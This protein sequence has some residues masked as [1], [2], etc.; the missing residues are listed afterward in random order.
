[1]TRKKVF[2]Y[3]VIRDIYRMVY[4]KKGNCIIGITGSVNTGKSHTAIRIGWMFSKRFNI[5][6]SLVYSVENLI[7]RSL[8]FIRYKNR[9]LDFN[10]VKNIPDIRDWLKENMKDIRVSP[11]NV[12]IMDE[13]GALGAYV[14]EFYSMDNKN[15]AKVIQ[16]WRI[17]RIVCIFVVPEDIRLAESTISRFMNMEIKMIGIRDDG[18]GAN[19]VANLITGWNKRKK[20]PYKRRMRG[21]RNGG[22]II[23]PPLPAEIAEKYETFSRSEKI[24]AL[25][26]MGKE[27]VAKKEEMKPKRSIKEHVKYVKEH[28]EDFKNKKGV[29]TGGTIQA[30]LGVSSSTAHVIKQYV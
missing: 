18:L 12:I 14:R 17:L 3:P 7:D 11:G 10:F 8:H 30:V 13:T 9:S 19:A 5:E 23:V 16:I 28:I 4:T 15:L 21:C 2:T 1:M 29:V 6:T 22:F 24:A 20:E 25:V 26:K 27:F